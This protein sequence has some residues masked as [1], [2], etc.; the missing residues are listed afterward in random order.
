MPGLSI[1]SKVKLNNGEEMPIFGLG[2]KQACKLKY[3][4][5]TLN[6]QNI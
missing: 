1:S 6:K 5:I 3:H 4:Y 2:K